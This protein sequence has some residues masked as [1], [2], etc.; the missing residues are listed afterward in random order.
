VLVVSGI[1]LAVEA[2]GRGLG[3]AVDA[4]GQ[5]AAIG[6]LLST[7]LEHPNASE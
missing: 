7:G 6:R 1:E 2:N 3:C 4:V 5:V